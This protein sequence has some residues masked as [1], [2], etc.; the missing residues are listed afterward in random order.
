MATYI[1]L[2]GAWEIVRTSREK[3]VVYFAVAAVMAG[4]AGGGV[5]YRPVGRLGCSPR[6]NEV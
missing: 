5:G 2:G 3:H 6:K 4:A 1:N